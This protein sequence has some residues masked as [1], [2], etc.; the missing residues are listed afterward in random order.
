MNNEN[1]NSELNRLIP[2]E[3]KNDEFYAILQRITREEN[4]KTVLEIGS[5]SGEGSTEAFVKRN[6][7][8]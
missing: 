6:T 2:P 8:S 5:S 1:T 7:F 4:I 3:I